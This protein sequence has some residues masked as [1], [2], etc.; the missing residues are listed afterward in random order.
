MLSTE[1]FAFQDMNTAL[2]RIRDGYND[3]ALAPSGMWKKL[4]DPFEAKTDVE[5]TVQT[6]D[7]PTHFVLSLD[8]S[9]WAQAS[10]NLAAGSGSYTDCSRSALPANFPSSVHGLR[11]KLFDKT[12]QLAATSIEP[13]HEHMP[14]QN[15]SESS[16]SGPLALYAMHRRAAGLPMSMKAKRASEVC[17]R[18]RIVYADIAAR[19]LSAT[20][21][22]ALL[23]EL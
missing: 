9:N 20:E 16:A 4:S 8:D 11:R 5:A 23:W 13:D 3:A 18:L 14:R 6:I 10:L 22:A 12:K 19:I 15:D 21:A 17:A 1:P 7:K 2:W